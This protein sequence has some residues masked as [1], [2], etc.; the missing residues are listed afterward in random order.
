R[1][2]VAVTSVRRTQQQHTHAGMRLIICSL[3]LIAG[4]AA[5]LRQYRLATYLT[6]TFES[7]IRFVGSG[8]VARRHIGNR[9]I[10]TR[11]RPVLSEELCSAF[12]GVAARLQS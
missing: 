1:R 2:R 4:S 11:D 5:L 7:L 8:S 12:A 6:T 3:F 10:E 9:F